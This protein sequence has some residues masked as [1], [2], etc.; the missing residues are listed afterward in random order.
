MVL[1]IVP[2]ASD[3]VYPYTGKIYLPKAEK[4]RRVSTNGREEKLDKDSEAVSGTV[5]RIINCFQRS[6]QIL[7]IYL[8]L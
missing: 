1:I 5:F 6:K 4:Q 2:E 3:D 8:S 7:Y